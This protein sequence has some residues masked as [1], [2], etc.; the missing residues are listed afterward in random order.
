VTA[1]M[2]FQPPLVLD[3]NAG[4]AA[5][6]YPISLRIY[7]S[8]SDQRE[9][10]RL[11]YRAFRRAGWIAEDPR[12][13]FT[14]RYDSLPS[15][16]AVG[17][18]H[19]GACIGSLRLAFGGEGLANAMPCEEQ[20]AVAVRELVKDGSLRLVEFSRMAVDPDLVNNS[21]RT[22]LYASLVRAGFIL[23][24]AGDTHAAL[25]AVHRKTSPFYRAM[26]GFRIIGESEGYAEIREPT[27]FLARDFESLDAR[28]RQRNAFFTVSAAEIEAARETLSAARR[29]A[30]A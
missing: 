1:A 13:E 23:G 10:Y 11:R 7:A 25:I 14:D 5:K 18:F 6:N 19:N 4:N 15:T 30:A 8:T 28:R 22:T 17:A 12:G 16:L 2:T 9:L 21:F 29:Q 20:F 27:H 3:S 24:H 26:C